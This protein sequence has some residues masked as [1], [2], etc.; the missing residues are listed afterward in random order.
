MRTELAVC[1]RLALLRIRKLKVLLVMM[2]LLASCISLVLPTW[3][4]V[5]RVCQAGPELAYTM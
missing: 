2:A 4:V 3:C 5:R 1:S